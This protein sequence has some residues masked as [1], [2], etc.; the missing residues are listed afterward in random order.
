M[1]KLVNRMR[2]HKFEPRAMHILAGAGKFDDVYMR[3][4][5]AR[6]PRSFYWVLVILDHR[7]LVSL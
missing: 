4:V 2:H 5:H 1:L 3:Y 6:K 7:S